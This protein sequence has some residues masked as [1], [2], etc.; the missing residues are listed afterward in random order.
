MDAPRKN[1]L[2][3]EASIPKYSFLNGNKAQDVLT[4]INRAKFPTIKT[5]KEPSQ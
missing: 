3:R 2:F 4:G 5:V 1:N